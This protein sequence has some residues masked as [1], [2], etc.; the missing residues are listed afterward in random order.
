MAALLALTISTPYASGWV[1]S[2]SSIM[3][4]TFK[5][6]A[7]VRVSVVLLQAFRSPEEVL[8]GVVLHDPNCISE[9]ALNRFDHETVSVFPDECLSGSLGMRRPC[10]SLV[11]GPSGSGKTMFALKHL[12]MLLYGLA[13]KKIYFCV[14]FQVNRAVDRMTMDT[15]LTFPYAVAAV[16]QDLIADKLAEEEL[17]IRDVVDLHLNVILDD[18]GGRLVDTY[19]YL[20]TSCDVR[21]VFDAIKRKCCYKFKEIH[22]TV[23]GT[24]LE[25]IGIFL[26]SMPSA[27]SYRM[28][29][30]TQKNLESM[31]RT[32]SHPNM[33]LVKNTV[34]SSPAL[35][36]LVS[37]G[38]CA[39]CLSSVMANVPESHLISSVADDFIKA[40]RLWLLL[41]AKNKWAL[42]RSV[43]RV[44]N[45]AACHPTKTF[46]PQFE[47]LNTEELRITAHGLLD[48][49]VETVNDEIELY[50]REKWPSYTMTP[51][52]NMILIHLLNDGADISWVWNHDEATVILN[53]LNHMIA[54]SM[55]APGSLGCLVRKWSTPIPIDD[56]T[57][58]PFS[59]PVVDRFT[60][61]V[62]EP[63]VSYARVIAPYRLTQT[64][65]L[66]EVAG[67]EPCTLD[68]Q[69][70][71]DKLG[72]TNSSKHVVQQYITSGFYTMWEMEQGKATA[73]SVNKLDLLHASQPTVTLNDAAK[74]VLQTNDLPL[75]FDKNRPITAV[76]ATNRKEFD[77][78]TIA[79]TTLTINH[80]DVDW[81]GKLIQKDLPIIEQLSGVKENV[82]FRFLFL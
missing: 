51:A 20:K 52:L 31:L 9:E 79:G 2:S 53:E 19:G 59:I 74:Q 44:L 47:D 10:Y 75:A 24:G 71:L 17:V 27:I 67:S 48:V 3:P 39:F 33:D 14:H 22:V 15:D 63:R 32:I 72:L 29:P 8:R 82:E 34:Q 65:F 40:S 76:F 25:K 81:Q 18:V 80:N 49:H 56:P 23:V 77:F 35:Q 7:A 5:P 62:N 38:R 57:N 50:H 58:E 11:L 16:V 45:K 73:P 12:P 13:V 42:A 26:S 30:W 28:Q 78:K 46:I 43:L 54:Q 36:D 60:I 6:G 41:T 66:A 68:M 1:L 37:N 64:K 55:D 70:E 69:D 4:A 21:D 61:I